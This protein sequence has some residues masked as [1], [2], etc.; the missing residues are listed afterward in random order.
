[1][2]DQSKVDSNLQ[3]AM[4]ESLRLYAD[5]DAR[6]FEYIGEDVRVYNLDSVE[7]S[8]GREAF[9]SAFESTFGVRRK[10]KVL[11]SDVQASD[12]QA[13]LS[14]TLEIS[15]DEIAMFVRQTVIWEQA[16]EGAWQMSHIHNALAG[17]PIAA[18]GKL[19]SSAREVQ[20]LNE[21]IATVAAAVGVAQ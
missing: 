13:V 7:P 9:R 19:P 21:R 18:V 8:V 11:H 14:Q 4:D 1:V 5:G 10:V 3:S 17:R 2:N 12:R 15:I 16:A 6:F 20:V